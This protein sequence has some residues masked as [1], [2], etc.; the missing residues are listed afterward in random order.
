MIWPCT[1]VCDVI[2]FQQSLRAIKCC[3]VSLCFRWTR[4]RYALNSRRSPSEWYSSCW[5]WTCRGIPNPLSFYAIYHRVRETG[6]VRPSTVDRWIRRSDVEESTQT[7]RR[8][9][10]CQHLSNTSSTKEYG[11]FPTNSFGAH[12]VCKGY[13]L[14][15][16][17]WFSP[18]Q[19]SFSHMVNSLL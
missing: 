14:S 3:S 17:A 10:L 1:L 7:R 18:M 8:E 16:Y 9:S 15:N 11:G 2:H 12:I 6:T 19:C 13:R 4:T 5:G